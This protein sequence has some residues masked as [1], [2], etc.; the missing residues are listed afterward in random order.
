MGDSKKIKNPDNG[1]EL[2]EYVFKDMGNEG[3]PL[4]YDKKLDELEEGPGS[5]TQDKE[6]V[7]VEETER[8][9]EAVMLEMSERFSKLSTDIQKAV[10]D[11]KN[12]L[13]EVQKADIQG[14]IEKLGEEVLPGLKGM[15]ES[16][17]KIDGFLIAK[18]EKNEIERLQDQMVENIH[19]MESVL[20]IQ[21]E[22]VDR[23]E[24][25]TKDLVKNIVQKIVGIE[26]STQSDK[27][28]LANMTL[29]FEEYREAQKIE[30]FFSKQDF[31]TM[32][33]KL[34]SFFQLKEMDLENITFKES[35]NVMRG[36][37][38]ILTDKGNFDSSIEDKMK[39]I[40]E[41]IL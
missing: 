10:E 9:M 38:L 36:S 33:E 20:K 35:P 25:R 41:S 6:G 39:L 17:E 8:L 29:L 32:K 16:I 13:L 24:E 30:I 22:R 31:P 2:E 21:S 7:S 3:H 11:S 37:F 40:I 19:K 23:L 12:S 4:D 1:Q 5:Q 27:I 28:I 26:V 15:L 14:S 18:D 34:T